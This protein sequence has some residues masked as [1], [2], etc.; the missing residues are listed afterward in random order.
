MRRNPEEVNPEEAHAVM[1]IM[2]ATIFGIVSII[3]ALY[4][5]YSAFCLVWLAPAIFP[6]RRRPSAKLSA[7]LSAHIC[8]N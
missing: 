5:L 6:P 7:A 4:G 2:I 8:H 3:V 1:I